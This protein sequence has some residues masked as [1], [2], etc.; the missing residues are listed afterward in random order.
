MRVVVVQIVQQSVS[1][2]FDKPLVQPGVQAVC[3]LI[4][5]IL[6]RRSSYL[7]GSATQSQ[8]GPLSLVRIQHNRDATD[9]LVAEFVQHILSVKRF[10]ELHRDVYVRRG[11]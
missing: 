4:E 11:N 6:A 10:G 3:T 7:L 1:K 5:L 2:V 8:K 9:R